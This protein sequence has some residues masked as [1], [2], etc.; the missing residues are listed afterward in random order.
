MIVLKWGK[1]QNATAT[2]S[3]DSRKSSEK[4]Y[5]T[6]TWNLTNIKTSLTLGKYDI[7]IVSN[8]S[9]PIEDKFEKRNK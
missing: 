4:F 1:H 6:K 5:D 9:T 2:A 8:C 3:I 7:K